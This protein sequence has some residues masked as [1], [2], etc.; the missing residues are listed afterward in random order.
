MCIRDRLLAM[1]K[2][3]IPR[4]KVVKARE[5]RLKIALKSNMAKR[6]AQ[7]TAR[8][9]NLPNTKNIDFKLED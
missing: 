3:T 9:S 4:K 5:E 8:T 6:K 7:A 1:D 2:N